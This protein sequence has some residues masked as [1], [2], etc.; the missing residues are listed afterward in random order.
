[1]TMKHFARCTSPFTC[2]RSVRTATL[3]CPLAISLLFA[4]QSLRDK[5]SQ[6]AQHGS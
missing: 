6:R 1:V 3:V 2:P 4:S 5:L